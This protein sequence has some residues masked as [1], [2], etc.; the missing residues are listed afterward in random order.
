MR[1]CNKWSKTA[2][3]AKKSKGKNYAVAIKHAYMGG[4]SGQSKRFK[5]NAEVTRVKRTGA[6]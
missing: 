2:P 3:T 1:R 4:L 5:K 6:T